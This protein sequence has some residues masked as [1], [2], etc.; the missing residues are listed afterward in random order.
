VPSIVLRLLIA[1]AIIPFNFSVW[2]STFDDQ[3]HPIHGIQVVFI[4]LATTQLALSI[5]VGVGGAGY[6]RASRRKRGLILAG[7]GWF[8]AVCA[9]TGLILGVWVPPYGK[10]YV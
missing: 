1:I 10:L 4:L 9:V 3:H 2:L 8:V 7:L 5:S 6:F